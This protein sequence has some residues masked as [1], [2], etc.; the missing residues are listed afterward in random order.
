MATARHI[1]VPF[2]LV[3]NAINNINLT[4]LDAA[5]VQYAPNDQNVKQLEGQLYSQV[6]L[7][8]QL[9]IA[10]VETHKQ[11]SKINGGRIDWSPFGLEYYE[12]YPFDR[13]RSAY[14]AISSDWLSP[15]SDDRSPGWLSRYIRNSPCHNGTTI[16]LQAGRLMVWVVN[17]KDGK[18]PD[19][20]LWIP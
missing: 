1:D 3:E 4:T 20:E 15:A 19:F 13:F 18:A 7:M 2:F 6:S 16:Q 17:S 11:R 8:K 12:N 9:H 5:T 14:K 10:A